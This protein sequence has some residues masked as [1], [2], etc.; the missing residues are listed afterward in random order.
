MVETRKMYF[1]GS[2]REL[3]DGLN[4]GR[5][6]AF[7]LLETAMK[8]E[9]ARPFFWHRCAPNN[10]VLSLWALPKLQCQIQER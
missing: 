10:D 4:L 5:G 7:E 3:G 9:L 2:H 6:D 1:N 8:F